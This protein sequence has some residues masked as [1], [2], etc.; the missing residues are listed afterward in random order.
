[1]SKKKKVVLTDI[2]KQVSEELSLSYTDV[3]KVV[4]KTCEI[5]AQDIFINGFQVQFTGFFT[6][7]PNFKEAIK[8]KSYFKED[9][10]VIP[11]MFVVSVRRGNRYKL[12]KK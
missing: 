5:T 4:K 6:L 1:M 2:A 3:L 12:K 11:P 7:V 10:F 9:K 8:K